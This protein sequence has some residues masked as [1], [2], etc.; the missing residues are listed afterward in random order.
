MDTPLHTLNEKQL[1]KH[2]GEAE[3]RSPTLRSCPCQQD[4]SPHLAKPHVGWQMLGPYLLAK[5][6]PFPVMPPGF[7]ER[8]FPS[9]HQWDDGGC[10]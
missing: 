3:L 2:R 5:F 4:P 9:L 10:C 7:P 6:P 8:L 1:G